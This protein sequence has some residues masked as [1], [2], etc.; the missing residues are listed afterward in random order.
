MAVHA[1]LPQPDTTTWLSVYSSPPPS[2]FTKGGKIFKKLKNPPPKL[3]KTTVGPTPQ[4]RLGPHNEPRS[5]SLPSTTRHGEA[6][7]G[8]KPPSANTRGRP[9]P[10]RTHSFA[11]SLLHSSFPLMLEG[12]EARCP[13]HPPSSF[14]PTSLPHRCSIFQ[15]NGLISAGRM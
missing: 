7:E 5:C 12:R 10:P 1:P 13:V 9:A 15:D 14:Q 3:S 2:P 4:N 8:D 6:L 11:P